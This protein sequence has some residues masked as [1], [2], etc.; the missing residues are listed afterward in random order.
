MTTPDNPFEKI[1]LPS[2]I[3]SAWPP[4]PIYWAI[5]A[6]VIVLS[7]VI[8]LLIKRRA[9][10]QETVN[11]TL[12]ALV[13]LHT[14]QQI[15]PVSFALLNQLL[16]GLCLQYYPRHQIASLTGKA[17]FTFLQ[18]HNGIKNTTLFNDQDEF[19][20]R[21]YQQQAYCTE[22]DFQAVKPWIKQFPAQVA[23]LK[24]AAVSATNKHSTGKQHV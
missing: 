15:E 8:Y 14:Q 9:K 5:L 7:A 11:K 1:I 3:P 20:R 19:C 12:I 4:A 16:K 13:E 6:L 2:E 17:W 21:L 22:Q 24:K 10:Q 18:Q 23:A